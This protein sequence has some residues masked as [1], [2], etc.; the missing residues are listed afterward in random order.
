MTDC[1]FDK[2]S[3]YCNGCRFFEACKPK[4]LVV[5]DENK[6]LVNSI[7]DIFA[8]IFATETKPT[9]VHQYV[10]PPNYLIPYPFNNVFEGKKQR[11][12]QIDKRAKNRKN[13]KRKS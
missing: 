13:R 8:D 1:K 3:D 5:D 2:E 11:K 9:S 10:I 7:A 4:I 6:S 12:N